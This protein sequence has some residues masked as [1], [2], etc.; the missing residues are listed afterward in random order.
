[1]Q[2]RTDRQQRCLHFQLEVWPHAQ[3]LTTK[4]HIENSI[5]YFDIP[6]RHAEL[7]LRARSLVLV[8]EESLPLD[9]VDG[10]EWSMLED[11][12]GSGMHWD[13]LSPSHFVK[14]TPLLSS[15]AEEAGLSRKED[16]LQILLQLNEQIHNAFTYLPKSTAVDSP[17]DIALEN[18]AGVCQDFTHVMIALLRK[19]GIPARYISGYLVQEANNEFESEMANA[20]H[21]WV[22]AFL[23]SVGWIG[24]D[25]TNNSYVGDR[26]IRIAIGRDYADV[27]PTRGIYKGDVRSELTVGVHISET[28]DEEIPTDLLSSGQWTLREHAEVESSELRRLEQQQQQ[29]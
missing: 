7:L 26:H 11:E 16:P 27:S 23:P 9:G 4:D 12:A 6:K 19:L 13:W 20:S 17:I 10:S 28:E 24:L 25:P 3:V 18:R 1:M 29:Q 14:S 8:L 15:F 21:A 2:P 5:H 22:E